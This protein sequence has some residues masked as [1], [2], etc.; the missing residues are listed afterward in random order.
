MKTLTIVFQPFMKIIPTY[1]FILCVYQNSTSYHFSSVKFNVIIKATNQTL[2][3]RE[4]GNEKSISWTNVKQTSARK[5]VCTPFVY[6]SLCSNL[7]LAQY[8]WS[9]YNQ[10]LSLY[11][12][13]YLLTNKKYRNTKHW[14]G[15]QN[16]TKWDDCKWSTLLICIKSDLLWT[17]YML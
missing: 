1:A 2:Y 6:Q 17:E 11:S 15:S 12:N 10:P 9:F 7:L 13:F 3:H 16:Q 4:M 14:H 8:F 5:S